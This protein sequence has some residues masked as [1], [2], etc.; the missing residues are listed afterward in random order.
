MP[1]SGTKQTPFEV[2]FTH[3]CTDDLFM[4]QYTD[5]D[6]VDYDLWVHCCADESDYATPIARYGNSGEE[7]YSGRYLAQ[8][9]H[10]LFPEL[11]E[12]WERWALYREDNNIV[13]R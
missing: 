4:G 2:R 5:P 3:N 12:C 13:P 10:P 7:Y 9:K 6:G 8:S 1:K 11:V